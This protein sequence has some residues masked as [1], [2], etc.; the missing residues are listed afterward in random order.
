MKSRTKNLLHTAVALVAFGLSTT[1]LLAE[2]ASTNAGLIG[3]SS[4]TL[5][6]TH[7][8]GDFDITGDA[9]GIAF[10]IPV[11]SFVDLGFGYSYS[12]SETR[13]YWED[14]TAHALTA[15]ALF[16]VPVEQAKWFIEPTLDIAR[17]SVENRSTE[18]T[19]FEISTGFEMPV[20]EYIALTPYFYYSDF[21]AYESDASYGFG[22]GMELA[23]SNQVSFLL[24]GTIGNESVKTV[25]V[26]IAFKL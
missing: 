1:T 9:G 11:S 20:S 23:A 17:L 21:F 26:G 18:E 10:S 14:L 19:F 5:G 16:H 2:E 7:T 25:S 6:Y 24:G 4:L 15:S 12:F 8:K 3:R 22:L 13:Y